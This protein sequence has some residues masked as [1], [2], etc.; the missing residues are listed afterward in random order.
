MTQQY[1]QRNINQQGDS[2]QFAATGGV[3]NI[4]LQPS[5]QSI[6]VNTALSNSVVTLPRAADAG[7][8]AEVTIIKQGAANTLTVAA[9]AGDTLVASAAI[10]NPLV[11]DWDT[12]TVKADPRNDR[13]IVTGSTV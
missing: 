4:T 5:V 8:N 12:L 10:V 7:Q 6:Q 9:A 13:W 2:V 3:P 1:N 11:G